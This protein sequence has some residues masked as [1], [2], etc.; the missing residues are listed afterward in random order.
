V[1]ESKEAAIPYEPE[2]VPPELARLRVEE[3]GLRVVDEREDAGFE[4]DEARLRDDAD[5]DAARLR[6]DAD[7]DA[8]DARLRDD[9][10]FDADDARLRDDADFV[11]A[12]F[13]DDEREEDG[14]RE[15]DDE[16]FAVEDVPRPPRG[17]T[18][19]AETRLA[20]P[21][22]S[23]RRP[24]SSWSTRSSSTSRMR[25][26]AAV[27]SFARP[28]VDFA[29]SA[30]AVKVRSTAA[31]TA[32]TASTAPAAALSFLPLFLEFLGM[33]ARS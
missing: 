28:R 13:R 24:L 12:R 33:A 8:D 31:R 2:D 32:S 17:P 7:F 29:P 4:A 18:S 23:L 1:G 19:R 6:D 22:T 3:A 15:L 14:L 16:L 30:E 11:A 5:F 21:S 10:D 26:A 27:T 25:L 9:A 20:R